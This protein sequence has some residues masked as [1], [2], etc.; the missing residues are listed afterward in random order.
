MLH[1]VVSIFFVYGAISRLT[2]AYTRLTGKRTCF[3]ITASRLHGTL[4]TVPV[5]FGY[6]TVKTVP[7]FCGYGTVNFL[8]SF[9]YAN[10]NLAPFSILIS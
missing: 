1:K 2:Q 5:F 6:G 9:F 4:K 7:L 10:K 8:L 3:E